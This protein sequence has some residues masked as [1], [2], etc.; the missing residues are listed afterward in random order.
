MVLKPYHIASV[1]WVIKIEN[2]KF[3]TNCGKE[4][5]EEGEFCSSCGQKIGGYSE[6][7]SNVKEKT[8]TKKKLKKQ[9]I[10]PI[11]KLIAI[12]IFISV[13]AIVAVVVY[14]IAMGSFAAEHKRLLMSE[15]Q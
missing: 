12:I 9:G 7:S 14:D 4:I 11:F 8:E 15:L 3:C 5:E 1:K 13:I 2:Q 10:S 6:I